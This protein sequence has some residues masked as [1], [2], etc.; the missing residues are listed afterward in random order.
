MTEIVQG[1]KVTEAVKRERVENLEEQV[2][3]IVKDKPGLSI[4]AYMGL[5]MKEFKGKVDGKKVMEILK[6]LV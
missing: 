4:N 3:K 2:L 6:K 1:K 5:V